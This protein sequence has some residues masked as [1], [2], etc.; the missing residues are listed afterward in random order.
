MALAT[1]SLF[2]TGEDCFLTNA[3]IRMG[4]D[5]ENS[6]NLHSYEVYATIDS[7]WS[8][9]LANNIEVNLSFEAALGMLTGDGATGA[10]T[11]VAPTLQV[12]FAD[13]PIYLTVGSGPSFYSEDGYD[14][15]DM[16]GHFHFTS[17]VG[18]GW[19]VSEQWSVNY[20]YQ[21]TSNADFDE[22][23]PGLDMHTLGLGYRF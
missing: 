19:D 11:R 8:W 2:A 4:V 7:P 22:P 13:F 1:S 10:Y 9:S 15:Y 17:R 3:G 14:D 6:L 20:G 5:D 18:L 21:H 16:G 12:S 23:N